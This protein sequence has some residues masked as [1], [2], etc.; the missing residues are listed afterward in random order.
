MEFFASPQKLATLIAKCPDFPSLTFIA[1]NAKGETK[2]NYGPTDVNAV[3][4]GV[5]PAREVVQPSVVDPASFLVWKDEAFG[6]WVEEWRVLYG[7]GEETPK[8]ILQEVSQGRDVVDKCRL[9]CFI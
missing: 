6:A 2:S 8:K 4:W 7:E 9:C 5:F 3:T 1:V